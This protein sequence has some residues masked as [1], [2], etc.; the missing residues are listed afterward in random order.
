MAKIGARI[1]SNKVIKKYEV[2]EARKCGSKPNRKMRE[3]IQLLA[4]L[5]SMQEDRNEGSQRILRQ[6]GCVVTF[7]SLS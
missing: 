4:E 6:L 7:L 2:Y 3:A 1:T 5:Q